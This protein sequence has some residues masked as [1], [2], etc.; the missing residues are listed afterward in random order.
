MARKIQPTTTDTTLLDTNIYNTVTED[1][2]DPV[3]PSIG[4]TSVKS[5]GIA[6]LVNR[7]LKLLYT[8]KGTNYLDKEEGTEFIQLF[9]LNVQD[10]VV[11]Q[12]KV[13][14]AIDDATD[15]I[16][17]IQSAQGVPNTERLRTATMTSFRVTDAREVQIGITLEVLTGD[18]TTVQLPSIT[19]DAL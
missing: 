14:D 11:A 3:S 10:A 5:A 12:A 9:N 16:I 15:Q 19:V 1:G 2:I 17:S 6:K 8:L 13:Q 7:F 4:T 18:Q